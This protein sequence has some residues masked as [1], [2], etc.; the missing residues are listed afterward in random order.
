MNAFDTWSP[1]YDADA[2]REGWSIF[3]SERGL[4]IQRIDFPEENQGKLKSDDDA[5]WIV[6]GGSGEH[7][8][9]ARNII[10]TH[11][12]DEWKAMEY[13]FKTV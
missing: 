8:A 3:E 10:L 1:K 9:T 6:M 2:L 11:N 13:W 12:P 5:W 4:Q 7:H